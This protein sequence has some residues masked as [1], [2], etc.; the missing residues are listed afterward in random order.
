MGGDAQA[1]ALGALRPG[2][3]GR[4]GREPGPEVGIPPP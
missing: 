2:A 4:E 1:E 3:H